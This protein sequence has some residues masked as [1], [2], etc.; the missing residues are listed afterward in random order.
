MSLVR[1]SVALLP[2]SKSGLDSRSPNCC[3]FGS[4]YVAVRGAGRRP[5][6]Y[7]FYD[8]SAWHNISLISR[9]T[10]ILHEGKTGK[11]TYGEPWINMTSGYHVMGIRIVTASGFEGPILRYLSHSRRVSTTFIAS[12]IMLTLAGDNQFRQRS[13]PL[14]LS[15]SLSAI[16]PPAAAI[17]SYG[18]NT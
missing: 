4:R 2:R 16:S 7:G 13:P 8:V 6:R 9:C 12:V 14:P 5:F 3:V 17:M 1:L 18:E 10:S 11:R 15:N